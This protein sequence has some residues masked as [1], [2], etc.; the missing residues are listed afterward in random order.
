MNL[1]IVIP[2]IL[3]IIVIVYF[4]LK[5]KSTPIP[6]SPAPPSTPAPTDVTKTQPLTINKALYGDPQSGSMVDVTSTL[7]SYVSNNELNQKAGVDWY[8]DA[9]CG[10]KD[11]APNKVKQLQVTY[12]IGNAKGFQVFT[13]DS[14]LSINV[15]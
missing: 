1:Y 5:N 12:T 7:Q 13:E 10:G 8:N 6:S 11:P 9:L 15:S 2:I 3:V 14:P 4:Y